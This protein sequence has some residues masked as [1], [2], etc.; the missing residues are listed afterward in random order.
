MQPGYRD[1]KASSTLLPWCLSCSIRHSRCGNGDPPRCRMGG[2]STH[3]QVVPSQEEKPC[4]FSSA[5]A[6]QS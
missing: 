6:C 3:M 5:C 1:E 2:P 4:A